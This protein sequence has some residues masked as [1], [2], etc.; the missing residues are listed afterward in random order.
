MLSF[1]KNFYYVWK[2]LSEKQSRKK[3]EKK[4]EEDLVRFNECTKRKPLSQIKSEQKVLRQY[5]GCYPYQY[6]R[7]GLYQKD[8][9]LTLEEMK[10]YV[11]N[12]FIYNLFFPLSFKDYG[13]LCEDKGLTYAILKSYGIPQ[14][15]M[16]FRFD[17]KKFYGEEHNPISN[18][19]VD[20]LIKGSKAEKLFVKPSF[21]AGG[22]G[23]ITFT[24]TEESDFINDQN[25]SLNHEF[26][27]QN[28]E[29]KNY[30]VQEGVSQNEEM[31]FIYP[32][33]VNTF[34]VVTE[35]KD[36]EVR[37]IYSLIRIGKGGNH[38]DNVHNGGLYLK[39]D[40]DTGVLGDCAYSLHCAQSFYKHPDTEYIFKDKE[41]HVWD[42]VKEFSIEIAKKFSEIRYIGWDIAATVNGP[43]VIEM[44][45]GPDIE[46]IQDLYGGIRDT[47]K[48]N[49]KQYWYKSDYTLKTLA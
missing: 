12:F 41:I 42:E 23:I 37:V 47:L 44:N 17:H 15:K 32:H 34:R 2:K 6:I 27:L 9:P 16:L 36:G 31:N 26:F 33:S 48:I 20:A 40:P 3:F 39:I 43:L 4:Y 11:P 30:V 10:T 45:N 46:L 13:I 24:R 25:I 29:F 14:P 49:P 21:G 22:F 1:K 38:I 19:R 28:L 5:W 8:C 35:Y 7:Y 18:D